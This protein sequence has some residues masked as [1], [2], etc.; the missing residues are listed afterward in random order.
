MPH[1]AAGLRD[2]RCMQ[3]EVHAQDKQ[4]GQSSDGGEF[5]TADLARA[6]GKSETWVR[7]R[8]DRGQ[9]PCRKLPNGHRIFDVSAIDIA[10]AL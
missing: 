8:A 9:I 1:P 7:W 3:Q 5:S 6:V 10:S 4:Q 2:Y